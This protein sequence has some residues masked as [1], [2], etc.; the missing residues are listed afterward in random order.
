MQPRQKWARV[1]VRL[2]PS[3]EAIFRRIAADEARSP[4]NLLRLLVLRHIE[5]RR[6]DI[7]AKDAV[8]SIG[9]F[10]P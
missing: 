2:K 1:Q 8:A 9:T 4:S 5:Q 6:A 3:D 7:H 10:K